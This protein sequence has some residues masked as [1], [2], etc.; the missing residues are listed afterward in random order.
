MIFRR[1]DIKSTVNISIFMYLMQ[2]FG[3]GNESTKLNPRI[4]FRQGKFIFDEIPGS[5]RNRCNEKIKIKNFQPLINFA[6]P[7]GT[8]NT[9]L[10]E[11]IVLRIPFFAVNICNNTT[12]IAFSMR[13]GEQKKNGFLFVI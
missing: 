10:Y 12:M 1:T 5:S 13:C 6:V 2:S 3:I 4:I 9:I 8:P 11:K 7:S